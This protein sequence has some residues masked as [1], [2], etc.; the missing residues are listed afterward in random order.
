MK[1]VYCFK[2]IPFAAS[3]CPFCHQQTSESQSNSAKMVV[4]I[5]A[6]GLLG[7]IFGFVG[8]LA[9]AVLGGIVG[10]IWAA[11]TIPSSTKL[12]ATYAPKIQAVPTSQ[13]QAIRLPRYRLHP[14]GSARRVTETSVWVPDS[15]KTVEVV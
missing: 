9:G 5:V 6:G 13:I 4:C 1:C 14:V 11:A 2:D 12:R 8:L 7:L 10:V 15:A 3:V